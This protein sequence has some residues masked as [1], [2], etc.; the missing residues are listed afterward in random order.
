M[1]ADRKS[2]PQN[3]QEQTGT[4]LAGQSR[5]CRRGRQTGRCRMCFCYMKAMTMPQIGLPDQHPPGLSLPRSKSLGK[6]CVGSVQKLGDARRQVY[7][8]YR[9]ESFDFHDASEQER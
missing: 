6:H 1:Q 5:R 8:T 7:S 2:Q 3:H 9:Y 4:D